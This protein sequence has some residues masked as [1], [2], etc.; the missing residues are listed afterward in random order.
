MDDYKIVPTIMKRDGLS[1]HE[2]I[3]E[4]NEARAMVAEGQSPEG[5][6]RREFGLEPDYAWDLML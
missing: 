6:C 4:V 1:L 5:V 3:E 2:A